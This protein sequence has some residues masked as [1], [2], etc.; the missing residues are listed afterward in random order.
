MRDICWID[1][2]TGGLDVAVHSPLSFAM[3]HTRGDRILNTWKTQI[4]QLPLVV[5]PGAL[6][7]NRIN[8][9]E[10][11]LTFENFRREYKA[12]INL[13]FYG[14]SDTGGYPRIKPARDNM[15]AIGGQNI[16]FDVPWLQRVLGSTWTGLYFHGIDLMR[17]VYPLV[18]L[19][20]IPQPPDLKLKTL[21]QILDVKVD[22]FVLH[23]CL[24]D[25]KATFHCWL[26][27]ERLFQLH[28]KSGTKACDSSFTPG[29]PIS[30]GNEETAFSAL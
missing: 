19:G 22:E 1:F 27:I 12:Q 21:C 30:S 7:I 17:F 8:L 20:V 29:M 13:W 5:D 25:V 4:R 15:P 3:I 18:Q 23:D 11:G 16:S 2:E 14:G 10:P 26:A 6:L 28:W 24:E 9:T